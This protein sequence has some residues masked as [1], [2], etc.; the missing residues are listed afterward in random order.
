MQIGHEISEQ[1]SRTREPK[2]LFQDKA[3]EKSPRAGFERKHA[4]R[5]QLLEHISMSAFERS[6]FKHA[7][8]GEASQLLCRP[9]N[10]IVFAQ[11]S[12]TCTRRP[13]T[14]IGQSRGPFSFEQ[15]KRVLRRWRTVEEIRKI[16]HASSSTFERLKVEA[17]AVP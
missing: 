14:R 10:P 1:K 9:V 6:E 15:I 3:L 12:R 16:G 11:P 7:F 13:T 8:A 2:R 17:F 5:T 4:G